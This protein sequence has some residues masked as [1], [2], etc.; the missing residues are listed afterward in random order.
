MLI[1]P[2]D[3]GQQPIR[4]KLDV[5]PDALQEGPKNQ[6]VDSPK[7]MIGDYKNGSSLRNALQITIQQCILKSQMLQA[8]GEELAANRRRFLLA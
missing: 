8:M 5:W 2:L 4:E 7:G 1:H 6:P 3:P